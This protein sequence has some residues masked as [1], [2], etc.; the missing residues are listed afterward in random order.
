MFNVQY[1]QTSLDCISNQQDTIIIC[2]NQAI[3]QQFIIETD[4][5]YS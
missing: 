4:S 2:Q 1:T 3:Q 5:S